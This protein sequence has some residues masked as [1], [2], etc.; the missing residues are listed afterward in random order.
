MKSWDAWIYKTVTGP[1]VLHGV[2]CEANNMDEKRLHAEKMRV[3]FMI[4][5]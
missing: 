3:L 4:N 2:E 5:M 1:V